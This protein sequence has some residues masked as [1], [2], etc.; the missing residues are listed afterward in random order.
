MAMSSSQTRILRRRRR[1]NRNP[2][3]SQRH[4]QHNTFINNQDALNRIANITT[5]STNDLL[6]NEFF[7]GSSFI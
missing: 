5:Q 2:R 6:I 3:L 4:I 1:R 7:N